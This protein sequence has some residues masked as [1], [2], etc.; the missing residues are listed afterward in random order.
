MS[1]T[2]GAR[3]LVTGANGCIGAWVVRHLMLEGAEVVALDLAPDP[4]RIVLAL[5]GDAASGL[6]SV[7]ADVTDL[8]AIERVIDEH[9]ITSVIHLAA[10]Q[11]PFCRADPPLGARVNVVGT[12]NMLEAVRRRAE[13]MRHL[14]YA[15]SAAAIDLD[16]GG[17]PSTIYGVYKRANEGS[18]AVYAREHGLASIGLRP[19][20]VYGP[21]RDQG[22]TSEPTKAMLAA[23]AGRPYR[24]GF[25]GSVRMQY[26]PDIAAGFVASARAQIDGA[27]VHD[28][29]G[30]VV[31]MAEVVAAIEAVAPESE[32]R[33]TYA[34][35]ELQF[36]SELDA[37]GF[38]DA[39]G[40]LDQ[41]PF[42]AGV[43]DSVERFRRLLAAGLVS[44]GD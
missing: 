35:E 18:A 24:I 29:P 30:H 2:D 1:P 44:A 32:G 16:S 15:S 41:T 37:R 13:R 31:T 3:Y 28:P 36:P 20:T 34:D 25:G 39:V 10:L 9:E 11:I 22:V 27:V 43:R 38:E 14:V 33:L 7:S 6:E 21:G 42:D 26:A 4:Y 5:D 12:V 23:A 17:T 8:D 19:H 40:R